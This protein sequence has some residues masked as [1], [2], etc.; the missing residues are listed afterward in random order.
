MKG[1]QVQRLAYSVPESGELLGISRASAYQAVRT[2]QI[3]SIRVGRRILVPRE[4]FDKLLRGE[5]RPSPDD[6][7]R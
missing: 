7:K 5:S 6:S 4:Q 3:P 2:G 1:E